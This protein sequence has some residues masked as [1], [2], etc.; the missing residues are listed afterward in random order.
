VLEEALAL[1]VRVLGRDHPDDAITEVNLAVALQE[2]GRNQEALAHVERG[3]AIT[4][5]SLGSEHPRMATYLSDRGEILNALGRPAEARRSFERARIIWERELGL[6]NR[7]LAYALTGIGISYLS[8]GDALSALVPLERAFKIRRGQ[9]ADPTKRAETS[10]ALARA[11]WESRR[12]R[13]RARA[14]AQEAKDDYDRAQLA[15]K[16][17]SVQEWLHQHL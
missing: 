15:D 2:L 12:D 4:E 9:E 8:E 3:M 10:F 5:K 14:L 16:A 17:V 1:K 6:E 13:G 7:S 11:L